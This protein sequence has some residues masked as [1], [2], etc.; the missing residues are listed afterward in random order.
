VRDKVGRFGLA[1]GGTLFLDE[2]GELSLAAQAKILRAIESREIFRLGSV[3][4]RRC[5]VRILAATHRDLGAEVTA[6]RFRADLYYRL[7]VVRLPVPP[8]TERRSDIAAIAAQLLRDL[9]VELGCPAPAIDAEALAEL[10]RRAWPGNV[11]ELRNTLEHALVVARDPLRLRLADLPRA[12]D[13]AAAPSAPAPLPVQLDGDELLSTIRACGG[14]AG[15][16]RRL[17][18]S[19]TTLYRR[20]QRLGLDPA[21]V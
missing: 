6:G 10:E 7:A 21:T 12:L 20:L 14:K 11:R 9:A 13:P 2:I 8:L 3:R 4:P 17:N 1:D 5:R 15:A 16:A 19:R 18:M